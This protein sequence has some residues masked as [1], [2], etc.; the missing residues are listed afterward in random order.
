MKS[1]LLILNIH[2]N[3]D[4]C[5]ALSRIKFIDL[6]NIKENEIN[7]KPFVDEK[8]N[9]IIIIY[10]DYSGIGKSTYIRNKKNK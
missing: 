4:L 3:D 6:L 9:N 1:C 10:S 8:N 2:L 7:K 5:K